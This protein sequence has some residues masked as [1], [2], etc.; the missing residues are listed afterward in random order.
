[1]TIY[2]SFIFF[3]FGL[4][5]G[6][7]FNVVGLRL[8]MHQ[9]IILP[10]SHCPSCQKRLGFWELIPLFSFL[11]QLG[12]CTKCKMKI[13]FLYPAF[14]LLTGLLFMFSFM[15]FGLGYELIIALTFISGLIIIIISDLKYLIIP[16]E[17]ILLSA[18]LIIVEITI[19]KGLSQ[20]L[21]AILNGGAS[22]V[23]MFLLK[24]LG[25][26]LFKKE[27]LG[28][29]D[30]KLM[31]LI[32]L[33]LGVELAIFVT[34]ISAFIALPISLLILYYKKTNIITFGPFL[35]STAI[36][37]YLLQIKALDFYRLLIKY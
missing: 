18:F 11:F 17:I 31:F 2:Y 25:D 3:L 34:I 19:F 36:L 7:F 33:V 35:S 26:Y 22:F 9:S 21:I 5:C 37:L 10:P 6:S 30:V 32:G 29:G 16:D 13:S 27:S 1:M 14:E 23:F 20:A 4:I 8:P 15:V 24:S 28:G 12:K